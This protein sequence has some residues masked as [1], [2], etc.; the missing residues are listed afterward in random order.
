MEI[1]RK[2]FTTLYSLLITLSSLL[3]TLYSFLTISYSSGWEYLPLNLHKLMFNIYYST[4][5]YSHH[6]IL[7]SKILGGDQRRQH[8]ISLLTLN[9]SLKTYYY[10]YYYTWYSNILTPA[11]KP[12][13]C[14]FIIQSRNLEDLHMLSCMLLTIFRHYRL[15]FSTEEVRDISSYRV[16]ST[17]NF[18]LRLPVSFDEASHGESL[19][20]VL[21]KVL[22]KVLEKVLEKILEKVLEKLP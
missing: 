7:Q 2:D 6:H 21:K 9:P 14:H 1:Y 16:T 22:K 13:Y 15:I 18:W 17:L 8:I 3:F 12:S 4:R 19:G 11:T 10:Y 5:L 20:E